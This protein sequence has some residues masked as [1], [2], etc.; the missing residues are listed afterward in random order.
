MNTRSLFSYSYAAHNWP[1]SRAGVHTHHSFIPSYIVT[2]ESGDLQTPGLLQHIAPWTTSTHL[3]VWRLHLGL[4]KGT[5]TNCLDGAAG[6]LQA[7]HHAGTRLPCCSHH[8]WLASRYLYDCPSEEQNHAVPLHPTP[9]GQ[10]VL[11][12]WKTAGSWSGSLRRGQCHVTCGLGISYHSRSAAQQFSATGLSLVSTIS[13]FSG[14]DIQKA[15]GT[16]PSWW[17]H[18]ELLALHLKTA[19]HPSKCN[20]FYTGYYRHMQWEWKALHIMQLF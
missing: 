16:K 10:P 5:D 12:A 2:K 4:P 6:L 13:H 20:S 8:G 7:A 1:H 9:Q 18:P 11:E 19:H 17:L 14:S 3:V 15:V